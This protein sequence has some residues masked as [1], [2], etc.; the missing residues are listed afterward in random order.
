MDDLADPLSLEW[1]AWLVA[2]RD[3][4][5]STL[6]GRLYVLRTI[7]NAGTA[8]REDV[9]AWWETRRALSRATRNAELSHLR[10]FYA[11][12]RTWEHREDDPTS[13]LTAPK[14]PNGL[15]RPISRADFRTLL[16][17]LEP[18]MRRAVCLGG[19]AGLRISEAARLTWADIDTESRRI[20]VE[21]SKAMR[22]RVVGIHPVLLDSLLPDVGG[23]V[24]TAGGKA[25]SADTLS[26]KINRAIRR[27]GVDATYHQ[28]RHRFATIALA[29]T[30]N[31]LA[32]SR[33]LGH[34]SPATTAIYAELAD[35]DLDKIAAAVVR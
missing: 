4:S 32:V 13:R 25:Y 14:I 20:R 17:N 6:K 31:L 23:N 9:E 7:G 8:T 30:G 19:W 2:E 27:A 35:N 22:T 10:M 1:L 5:R 16:D 12:C 24:V 11:W 26:R 33:A 21:E 34:S 3:V 15:P 18:D 28:L 29:E